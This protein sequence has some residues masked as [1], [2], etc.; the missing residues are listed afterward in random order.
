M[1]P[2]LHLCSI[3]S[4]HTVRPAI[5][6]SIGPATAT[7]ILG[8]TLSAS[9]VQANAN[10]TSSN[11]DNETTFKKW[12]FW[13]VGEKLNGGPFVV[14]EEYADKFRWYIDYLGANVFCEN[15]TG[16]ESKGCKRLPG[17]N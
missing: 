11:P 5:Q 12:R 14:D 10:V 13:Q 17:H 8:K 6:T 4:Q 15:G 3:I 9:I 7:F 1:F 2:S 16:D